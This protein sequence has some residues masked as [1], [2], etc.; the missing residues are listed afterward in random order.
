MQRIQGHVRGGSLRFE[1]GELRRFVGCDEALGD[2]HENLGCGAWRETFEQSSQ[3]GDRV[4]SPSVVRRQ[5]SARFPT[6]P[7]SY[8]PRPRSCPRA[9]LI[10]RRD[11]ALPLV[12]ALHRER[13]LALEGQGVGDTH[14][15]D[16][17]DGRCIAVDLL[18]EP[19][20]ETMIGS[21]VQLW[22][23]GNARERDAVGRVELCDEL[24]GCLHDALAA[25]GVMLPRS[26]TIMISRPPELSALEL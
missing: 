8:R 11:T 3:A 10:A 23:M 15:S 4:R 12:D 1:P 17:D 13:V 24:A 5:Q 9:S 22:A 14:V 7:D 25:P 19:L 21:K 2:V 16:S 26:A 18:E 20:D 6:S